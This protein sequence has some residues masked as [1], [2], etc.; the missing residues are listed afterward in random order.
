MTSQ[1]R[2]S[3]I[4]KM[5]Q[6]LQSKGLTSNISEDYITMG[7]LRGQV[8]A[9]LVEEAGLTDYIETIRN[10]PDITD[11]QGNTI[12]SQDAIKKWGFQGY[13]ELTSSTRGGKIQRHDRWVEPSSSSS[14][15]S[16]S[17]QSIS[18]YVAPVTSSS[19]TPRRIEA[20]EDPIAGDLTYTSALNEPTERVADVAK[21]PF[22]Y[23][24][25]YGLTPKEPEK[26]EP[27]SPFSY[28]DVYGLTPKEPEKEYYN[29]PSLESGDYQGG[30]GSEATA[31]EI[32]EYKEDQDEFV[33]K[34]EDYNRRYVRQDLQGV[35]E[36]GLESRYG[37][38]Y[39]ASKIYRRNTEP[40]INESIKDINKWTL[41]LTGDGRPD[42]GGVREP[43]SEK[44]DRYYSFLD[45]SGEKHSFIDDGN[46]TEVEVLIKRE[47]DK[48]FVSEQELTATVDRITNYADKS[49]EGLARKEAMEGK[50]FEAVYEQYR[51]EQ[52]YAS[53]PIKEQ[54]RLEE[55]Y[56]AQGV[57]TKLIQSLTL[58]TQQGKTVFEAIKGTSP[59]IFT[60]LTLTEEAVAEIEA[61]T[62]KFEALM[63]EA[64]L[65]KAPEDR[66]TTFDQG[67]VGD[68]I[69][70]VLTFSM[71]DTATFNKENLEKEFEVTRSDLA[72]M[73]HKAEALANKQGMTIV[74][75]EQD[76]LEATMPATDKDEWVRARI[77]QGAKATQ[78]AGDFALAMTP[79]VGTIKTWQDTKSIGMTALSAGLDVL[80]FI[81]VVGA[82]AGAVRTGT[83][84]ATGVSK[85]MGRA[86]VADAIATVKA[87]YTIIKYPAQVVKQGLLK[88]LEMILDPK[89]MPIGAIAKQAD[90]TRVT[91]KGAGGVLSED[92]A[93]EL[94]D[95]M[96]KNALEGKDLYAKVD[97]YS[98]KV[99]K[100][101]IM[102]YTNITLGHGSPDVRFALGSHSK[103][104]L[105]EAEKKLLMVQDFRAIAR[106][107]K[108]SGDVEG[109][110]KYE[111]LARGNQ[112]EA[113]V[114]YKKADEI[115]GTS[116]D[117]AYEV[118][119]SGEGLGQF[120]NPVGVATTFTK[121]NALGTADDAVY[122]KLVDELTELL[123]SEPTGLKDTV[124]RKVKIR[125]AKKAIDEHIE[126]VTK[127]KKSGVVF[128]GGDYSGTALVGTDTL[129]HVNWAMEDGVK[130]YKKYNQK[131]P[132]WR[133]EAE[134]EATIAIG[135][136]FAKAD[137][138]IIARDLDGTKLHMPI[139]GTKIPIWKKYGLKFT[140][141]PEDVKRIFKRDSIDLLKDTELRAL[142]D[143]IEAEQTTTASLKQKLV[144][145]V[146][147]GKSPSELQAIRD[148]I[149]RSVDKADTANKIKRADHFERLERDS[150]NSAK[151]ADAKF[152]EAL[153]LST[154]A[155]ELAKIGKKTQADEL[156]SL[157]R[158]A[159]ED[160]RFLLRRS[161]HQARI[162]AQQ[163][164]QTAMYATYRAGIDLYEDLGVRFVNNAEVIRAD[165][166][167]MNIAD[168]IGLRSTQAIRNNDIKSGR[169]TG[170]TGVS[171]ERVRVESEVRRA[172]DDLTRRTDSEGRRV[173]DDSTRRTDD[174]GRRVDDEIKA[175]GE[176]DART[177]SDSELRAD[178]E[179]RT[180]TDQTRRFED[181]RARVRDDGDG[182]VGGDEGVRTDRE[183]RVDDS[184]RRVLDDTRPSPTRDEG[185]KTSE[186]KRVADERR[187]EKRKDEKPKHDRPDTT[188]RNKPTTTEKRKPTTPRRKP[189][190][191]ST[192]TPKEKPK[193]RALKAG[194]EFPV[195]V[196]W[197]QGMGWRVVN[198]ETDTNV[199]TRK[200]PDWIKRAT[201][202]KGSAEETFTVHTYDN[203]PPSQKEL[204]MG[205]VKSL[206][207]KALKFRRTPK[208]NRK[209]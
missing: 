47:I 138:F 92:Q 11:Y 123:K 159:D 104:L 140:G 200:K 146:K 94:R 163:Q 106:A 23:D 66:S 24:D 187:D 179:G 117:F 185:R 176:E 198:L 133:A 88:P 1:K 101:P 2:Q 54:L 162:K 167:A 182:S 125:N 37:S 170:E 21:S 48:D 134:V 120:G 65:K 5:S 171:T 80:W 44:L 116:E 87:P 121:S 13:N 141:F 85:A 86:V 178:E 3:A 127:E 148:D 111:T 4:L 157:A 191:P 53:L 168:D 205:I 164:S 34:W 208:N 112:I 33:K 113:G 143:L 41:D 154:R 36:S 165:D 62:A 188:K 90:T 169:V 69:T 180:Q 81:P 35:D 115:K 89:R 84:T 18:S 166:N 144:D 77:D 105:E 56:E 206:V 42:V 142:D 50:E 72:K 193:S 194:K 52:I 51:Q 209:V 126:K 199:F 139:F 59:T 97:G 32:Y 40:P 192:S 149:A 82:G 153:A 43:D 202:K 27:Q 58:G 151:L 129:K 55:M 108:K 147:E 158:Q 136:K 7:I 114:L 197:K 99:E 145:G 189:P 46:L 190:E 73:Y 38:E 172:D 150:I 79:I 74:E 131:Q 207:S 8:D 181:D 184:E 60:D 132:L 118:I 203:D 10:A 45:S 28:D 93:L 20:S 67:V 161:N 17:S 96:V 70:E 68:V 39:E 201:K 119:P 15:S 91:T 95:L 128:M 64:E 29:A 6:Q 63:K 130:V 57:D 173:D 98:V 155:D 22:S 100:A 30:Y 102:K 14:S 124:A 110:V 137:D 16:S 31:Q 107:M 71:Q 175:R 195:E 174:E 49:V 61:R 78:V 160:G 75:S 9:D 109:A 135:T 103:T 177:R 26:T 12:S 152:E 204:D 83:K 196:G 156:R 19:P 122:T 183:R 25:V 186:E 76:F